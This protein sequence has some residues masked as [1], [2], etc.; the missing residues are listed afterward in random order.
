MNEDLLEKLDRFCRERRITR[1]EAIRRAV[2][3]YL[4]RVMRGEE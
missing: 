3:M 2:R 4:E 1:S